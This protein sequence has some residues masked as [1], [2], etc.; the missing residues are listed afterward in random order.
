M[1]SSLA[2]RTSDLERLRIGLNLKKRSKTM[3]RWTIEKDGTGIEKSG[4]GIEKSGTGIEKSGTG[5]E[6]SG[7]GIEKSG[8]GARRLWLVSTFA[9]L[10]FSGG[11]NATTVDPTG[12]LQLVVNRNTVA[13]SWIFDGSVFSGVSSLNNSF[14]SFQLTEIALANTSS[15]FDLGA[16]ATEVTGTGTGNTVKVTGT[17]TGNSVKVTGSGTGNSAQVTGS[18]TGNSAQVT[19]SGTGNSAQV[20]G[21]GTGSSAQ[22]TGSGTGSSAQVTGSGT[23][24]TRQV[25]GTGTGNARQVTGTG[26]GNSTFIAGGATDI[27]AVKV[28]LPDGTGLAMEVT[29][30]CGF[31]TVTVVDSLSAPVA[32]FERVPV[33]GDTGACAGGYGG[34]FKSDPGRDFRLQ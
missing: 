27:D 17:G 32:I 6:K 5:I 8:T 18:G 34:G 14:A 25:T 12:T 3:S 11:V 2:N 26:T 24:D 28:T 13:V 9:A 16:N 20:T 33:L 30:S 15:G 29:L 22:V 4:T 31:A 7:T 1:F 21:S 19:G 10:T 23:G